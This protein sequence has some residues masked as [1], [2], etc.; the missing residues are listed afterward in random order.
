MP[1]ALTNWKTTAAALFLAAG[2][3]LTAIAAQLD[4]NPSTVPDWDVTIG[5]IVAAI[6]L[7][8]AKDA[9]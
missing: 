8:F 2:S 6:G 3:L 9:S 7:F 1:K 4:A 5:L